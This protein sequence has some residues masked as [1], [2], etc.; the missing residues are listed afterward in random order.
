VS[1]GEAG[2][3]VAERQSKDSRRPRVRRSLID[4]DFALHV[5]SA[6]NKLRN[7]HDHGPGRGPAGTIPDRTGTRGPVAEAVIAVDRF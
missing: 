1:A 7:S 2:T 6:A 4:S 3:G 5:N